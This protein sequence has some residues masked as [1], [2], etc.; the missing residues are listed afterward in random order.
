M[1]TPKKV[2][3]KISQ[4]GAKCGKGDEK[5]SLFSMVLSGQCY[6]GG[7]CEEYVFLATGEIMHSWSESASLPLPIPVQKNTSQNQCPLPY[8]NIIVR[9]QA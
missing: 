9:A 2:L 7:L 4:M 5:Y 1:K 6:T 8:N 3:R